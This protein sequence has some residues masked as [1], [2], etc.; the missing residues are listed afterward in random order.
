[1]KAFRYIV[2]LLGVLSAVK[3]L[4]VP[5]PDPFVIA[6]WVYSCFPYFMY[7]AVTSK[8]KN[9]GAIIGGGLLMLIVDIGA[10]IDIN[11]FPS[12]S[13]AALGFLYIP[14]LLFVLVMP[15]GM[16]GGWLVARL[17][18]QSKRK[19]KIVDRQTKDPT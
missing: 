2:M 7:F 19:P 5:A 12:S 1:M 8:M 15:T 16:A 17:I 13:T 18:E 10:R 6:L 4:P 14:F 3:S 11:Y 9:K